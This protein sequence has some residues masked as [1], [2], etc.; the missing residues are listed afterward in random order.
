M[1]R[2]PTTKPSP[3]SS[4]F[5]SPLHANDVREPR[6]IAQDLGNPLEQVDRRRAFLDDVNGN[7]RHALAVALGAD[8]ELGGKKIAL[9]HAP[10]GGVEQPL[11]AERLEAVG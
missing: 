7:L 9:Q 11:A 1:R 6:D 4:S 5:A 10:L 3:I 2:P 8:D